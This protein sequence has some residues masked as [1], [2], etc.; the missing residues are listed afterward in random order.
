M[1]V[2]EYCKKDIVTSIIT[3]DFTTNKVS[4]ENKTDRIIDTAFGVNRNPTMEDFNRLLQRRC[5][6]KERKDCKYI[7]R[8]L[9]VDFYNL[10]GKTPNL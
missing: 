9:G 4:V 5:F 3:V 7:L 1:L 8:Q 10:A 2:I 6:P